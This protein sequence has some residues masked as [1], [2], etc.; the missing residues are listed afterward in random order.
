MWKDDAYLLDMLIYARTVREMNEGITF[1]SFQSDVTL[2]L[3]TM[4]ALQ[5]IGEAAGKVSPERRA[6]LREIPWDNIIGLRHRLVH[7][8][9]RIELPKI[10]AVFEKH[11]AELIAT[12]ERTVPPATPE[13]P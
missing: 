3:A 9:P 6:E 2:Q 10:W 4:R 1:E 8:Y 5:I 7:D 11:L 12:L 13:I